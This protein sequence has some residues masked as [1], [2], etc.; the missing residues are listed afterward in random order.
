ML[1]I[2]DV[3]LRLMALIT[4]KIALIVINNGEKT[5]H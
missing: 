5:N 2:Q 1:L 3:S 4:D